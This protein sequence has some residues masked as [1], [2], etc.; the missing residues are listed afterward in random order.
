MTYL[1]EIIS[2]LVA[3]S[4][5]A[6]AIFSELASK[7]IGSLTLNVVRM[8]MSLFFLALILWLTVGKP[9]PVYADANTWLWLSL[10]GFVGYVLGDYCLFKCYI[11]IGSRFGQLLMTVAAPVAAVAAWAILDE[12]MSDTAIIGMVVTIAGIAMSIFGKNENNKVKLKLPLIGVLYGLAAA[13][14]QG[15]GLVLSKYGMQFYQQSLDA[16]NVS[17]GMMMPVA[18]TMIRAIM[19]FAGFTVALFFFSRSGYSRINNAVRNGKAMIFTF[20]ACMFGPVIG[21]SLSLM[22]TLYTSTGVAQTIMALAPVFILLPAYLLFN[23]KI[24]ALEIIGAV[25]SVIGVSL[26]FI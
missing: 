21:V 19:G 25:V 15:V 2:I 22:A 13:T 17:M 23:Q 14:G 11:S 1:G 20:S 5:T 12:K 9:Y 3:V 4:W 18:S 8:S 6:S 16:N 7:K 26:F 10:S 24:T